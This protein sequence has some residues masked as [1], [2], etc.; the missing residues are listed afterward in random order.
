MA[1]RRLS[2]GHQIDKEAYSLCTVFIKG[3]SQDFNRRDTFLVLF[4]EILQDLM[5][6]FTAF[7]DIQKGHN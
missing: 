1:S 7:K 6:I 2:G 3:I 5:E 4:V